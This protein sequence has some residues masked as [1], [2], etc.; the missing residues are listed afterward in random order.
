MTIEQLR[1]PG[2]LSLEFAPGIPSLLLLLIYLGLNIALLWRHRDEFRAL[3]TRQWIVLGLLLLLIPPAHRLMTVKW[4]QR[5]IIPPGPANVLP[6]TSAISLPGLAAVAGVAYA[7][8]PGS[9]LV[10]SLVAGL[11]WARYTPLVVTDLLALSMWGYLL[12]AMLHQR[13]RGDI[14]AL[15]R[16]PLIAAP[17]ASLLT[18]ALLSL[19][20]LAATRLDDSLRIIDFV[21]ILWRNELPLWLLVGAGLGSVM[22]LVAL[23]PAWRLPQRA[24]RPSFYSRSLSVQFMVFSI[25]LVLL[26]MLF[27]VLA[28]TNRSVTLAREQSL[29]EMRRSARTASENIQKFFITGRNL[30]EAFAVEPQLLNPDPNVQREALNIALRVVP[31]YQQ[32]MLVHESGGE[33]L[34]VAS[35]PIAPVDVTLTAEE[36]GI[37]EELQGLGIGVKETRIMELP[38]NAQLKANG[39][40]V[41][42]CVHPES[43]QSSD[44]TE[45]FLIGRALFD[46]HPDIKA[47]LSA[48]QKQRITENGEL[49]YE[50]TGYVVDSYDWVV[51]HPDKDQIRT[52][53]TFDP[54][55]AVEV[56]DE[57]RGTVFETLTPEGEHILVYVHKLDG[58][59]LRVVLELPYVTVLDTAW[60]TASA[61]LIVQIAFGILLSLAIPILSSRITRPL[62]SLAHAAKQIAQGNLDE[63]VEI[64]G[65]DEV[66]QL[67]QAFEQM[68][69]HLKARLNELSML[70]DIAQKVSATLDLERGVVPILEGA[71]TET[72]GTVARFIT[73]RD[74]GR[75]LRT[76]KVGHDTGDL[77]KLDAVVVA[78]LLRRAEP[79]VVQDLSQTQSRLQLSSELR[80]LA[81]FP[82]L[83]QGKMIAALWVGVDR[84]GV[85]DEA[86]INFLSTLASQAAVL[87]ENARL[88]KTAEGGRQRLA[89]ILTST[90]DAILAVDADGHLLLLNPAAQH[91]FGIDRSAIGKPI[92]TLGLPEPLMEVLSVETTTA[93]RILRY[94]MALPQAMRTTVGAPTDGQPVPSVEVPLEDGRTFYASVAPIRGS[95][96]LTLGVVA[97]MRDVTH[98]KELD[99]MKSEFV[100]TVSHDLRSPLTSMRGYTTMLSM[101]GDLNDRQREYV[102][103]IL[104]GLEQMNRLVG[105]LL[106][107]RRVESGVGLQREPCHVGLILIEA[108]EALRSRAKAK[109]VTLRLEPSEGSPTVMGDRTLLRQSVSNLVD[110]AIKYTP[111]GGEVAV[112]LDITADTVTIRVS[113]TGIGIAAADQ[114]R[115]F[116]KFYRIK[117]RETSNI[118]GTGLGL[119]LVKSIV[120]RHG[121]RVWVESELNKGSTF[122]IE[123]PLPREE[124]E[125]A[126]IR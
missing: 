11:T 49:T 67:G 73:L 96:G 58:I 31:F 8:G 66:A 63:S 40:S 115:L 75:P 50:Y 16:Q 1:G 62:N 85:F 22:Q 109:G 52:V 17:L 48:L 13:Y 119:A 91:L 68:R 39:Y 103:R 30:I 38:L 94:Q 110:N 47:A 35:V 42:G 45:W 4:V 34:V 6:F 7:F 90:R 93:R 5:I 111:S 32:L 125:E 80:A 57:G 118:Q 108:V 113:D 23:R 106:D 24:D 81:A 36:L 65:D 87:M 89:A 78:A 3:T 28:V 112:G 100:A 102:Q 86:R 98:F 9:G 122:Y 76:Y 83:S 120:E 55:L 101:I 59:P 97:V 124:L 54:S 33:F 14:F 82:V 27:S 84:P 92:K 56:L 21:V 37:L 44:S 104:E 69:V 88:F 43:S 60:K 79:L 46:V 74:N 70:L 20:R 123:L 61:L 29:Q 51:A 25:P 121:G 26:S 18:V 10:A 71:L 72:E 95:E 107:L 117:R 114:D 64:A 15:L 116:E 53:R 41:I 105:D 12:G 19:S 126:G 2:P 99:E 77:S